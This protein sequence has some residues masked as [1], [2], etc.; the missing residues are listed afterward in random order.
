MSDIKKIEKLHKALANGRRIAI[1][2]YLNLKRE[3]SVG[4]IAS[5]IK[6]SFKSTS[7]HLSVLLSVDVLEKS[8][9]STQMFYSLSK[10]V[11]CIVSKT[12]DLV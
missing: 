11:H 3:A 10:P 6:L 12:L 4:R 1:L 2:S 8:Q 5:H 7:R 9:R